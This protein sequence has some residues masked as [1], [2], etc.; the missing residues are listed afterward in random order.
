MFV[1]F[2]SREIEIS[3]LFSLNCCGFYKCLAQFQPG[4]V[5]MVVTIATACTV[6]IVCGGYLSCFVQTCKIRLQKL[7]NLCTT[8]PIYSCCRRHNLNI[9]LLVLF[10]PL[11]TWEE[12]MSWDSTVVLELMQMLQ[13]T[14]IAT[15]LMLIYCVIIMEYCGVSVA[16]KYWHVT[17]LNSLTIR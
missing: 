10:P 14:L 12:F 15:M 3:L 17:I 11:F 2:R 6:C 13:H 9:W 1:F 16:K 8:A 7:A 5:W 4:V